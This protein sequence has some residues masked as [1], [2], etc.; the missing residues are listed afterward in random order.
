MELISCRKL[1]NDSLTLKD[2]FFEDFEVKEVSSSDEDDG[3]GASGF[4]MSTLGD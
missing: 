2:P 1:D 4:L 3:W